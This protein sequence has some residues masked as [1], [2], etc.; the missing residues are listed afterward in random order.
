MVVFNLHVQYITIFVQH[1][2]G[3]KIKVSTAKSMELQIIEIWT[4]CMQST[5]STN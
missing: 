1:S 4:L 3:A 2:S 5:R